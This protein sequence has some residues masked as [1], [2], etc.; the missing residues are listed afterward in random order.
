MDESERKHLD[1]NKIHNIIYM[2]LKNISNE[3]NTVRLQALRILRLLVEDFSPQ[4]SDICNFFF[5]ASQVPPSSCC[6]VF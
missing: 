3:D 2:I 4:L 5:T 1:E 6:C